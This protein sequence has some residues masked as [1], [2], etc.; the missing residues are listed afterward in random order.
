MDTAFVEVTLP[1]GT[2]QRYPV[3]GEQVTLGKSGEA[4]IAIPSAS[5]LEMEHLLIVP[6]GREGCWVSSSQGALTPTLRKGKAFTAELVPWGTELAIGRLKVR[7][8]NK[9]PKVKKE[10]QVS[11]VVVLGSLGI[12]AGLGYL[13]LKEDGGR[14][15]PEVEV[16]PPPIFA[17]AEPAC[18]EGAAPAE[19]AA[20][21]EY[22]AD[23]KSDRFPYDRQDGVEAV[24]FYAQAEAC[25]AQVATPEAV[26]RA[27]ELK[28]ARERLEQQLEADLAMLRLRLDHA[29][30]V[31]DFEAIARLADDLLELFE[32][33]PADEPYRQL[34]ERYSREARAEAER[35]KRSATRDS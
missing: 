22:R 9:Q 13:Y 6:R 12:L 27:A 10:Q 20:T 26:A 23:R 18:P 33:K 28:E 16:E 4:G 8:T 21:L 11:P 30:D 19:E 1:D 3:E 5:E 34:L 14:M 17:G 31:D 7:V 15:R 35:A 24:T 29:L 32:H 2:T 25:L